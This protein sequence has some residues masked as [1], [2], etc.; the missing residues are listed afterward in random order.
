MKQKM[1]EMSSRK[2]K[3]LIWIAHH[4][5]AA[6]LIER[7]VQLAK[8]E[9]ES[10]GHKVVIARDLEDAIAAVKDADI[11]LC[12]K[13]VPE[14]FMKAERLKWIQ[15]GSAGIEHTLFPELIEAMSS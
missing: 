15:L 14:I 13:I 11:M 6:F 10:H 12:W 3:A 2:L 8:E 9:L 5:E 1:L 4:L 7:Y